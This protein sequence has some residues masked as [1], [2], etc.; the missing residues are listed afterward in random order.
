MSKGLVLVTGAG[1]YFGGALALGLKGRGYNVRLFIHESIPD[2]PIN[3]FEAVYG[4]I[5]NP[6]DVRH[7]VKEATTIF[8]TAAFVKTKARDR[9]AFDRVNEGGLRNVIQSADSEG[10]PVYYTSSF[11]ALGPS[12]GG[13]KKEGDAITPNT[14]HNDYEKSKRNALILARNAISAGSQVVILLPGVIYG[15]GK[16]TSGN[17]I[18]TIIIDRAKGRDPMMPRFSDRRWSFAYIDDVVQGHISA[19]EREITTGEFILGGDNRSL[20]DFFEVLNRVSGISKPKMWV[21]FF[22]A[23]MK[24]GLWDEMVIFGLA[25]HEPKIT[26]EVVEIY[27]HSW[28]VSSDNAIRELGYKITQ[29][30]EGLER[31]VAWLNK[32]GLI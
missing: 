30:E 24:A 28:E 26:R 23:K 29:L 22:I 13:S 16:V 7:A 6:D 15:P 10:V 2:F 11:I 1:G 8:H 31:T 5:C 17:M 9:L 25:G 18:G 32:E 12:N 20:G 21:P 14:G 3:D 27:R 4:D 19:F